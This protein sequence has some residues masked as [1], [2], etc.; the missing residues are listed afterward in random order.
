ML[1]HVLATMTS[2]ADRSAINSVCK[3]WTKIVASRAFAQ[4]RREVGETGL[5]L[6]GYPLYRDPTQRFTSAAAAVVES[7]AAFIV[8]DG[9]RVLRGPGINSMG[10]ECAVLGDEVV[11]VGM[12]AGNVMKAFNV[13]RGSWRDLAAPPNGEGRTS[14][15][16]GLRFEVIP[17]SVVRAHAGEL[18]TAKRTR[19]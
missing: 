4:A 5:V 15:W 11:A 18:D 10:C 1:T 2:F 14:E 17:R 6:V 9:N 8:A 13:S 19:P 16:E 12:S 3:R 7:T